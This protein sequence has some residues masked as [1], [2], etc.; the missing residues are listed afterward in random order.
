MPAGRRACSQASRVKQRRRHRRTLGHGS[1][2]ESGIAD[3]QWPR[4]CPNPLPGAGGVTGTGALPDLTGPLVPSPPLGAAGFAGVALSVSASAFRSF[5]NPSLKTA[6]TSSERDTPISFAMPSSQSPTSWDVF[7][8]S[9]RE[10]SQAAMSLL[11][12]SPCALSGF[13]PFDNRSMN[14]S[15]SEGIS[16]LFYEWAGANPNVLRG[17]DR[18]T[19]PSSCSPVSP[20]CGFAQRTP[21][22]L[23][24]CCF[25]RRSLDTISGRNCGR[26]CYAER[27]RWYC[28]IGKPQALECRSEVFLA[29][30]FLASYWLGRR[31]GTE[32]GLTHWCRLSIR[33][34]PS[35]G[36]LIA[37]VRPFV[38]GADALLLRDGA[39]MVAA[40]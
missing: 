27:A 40:G 32:P 18:A 17:V 10:P 13:L 33:R 19:Q 25:N 37:V 28:S 30:S 35:D 16:G 36:S 7:T 3:S 12:I 11:L 14:S 29:D 31:L 21:D 9:R 24:W 2:R 20:Q 34:L 6:V 38:R 15:K 4:I 23:M 22:R 8:Q 5:S 39:N 1:L 26:A